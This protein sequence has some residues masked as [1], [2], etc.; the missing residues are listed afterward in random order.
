MLTEALQTGLQEIEPW[1]SSKRGVWGAGP[2]IL[3][4]VEL[5]GMKLYVEIF[6]EL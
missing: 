6:I 1:T 3:M 4:G 5:L 2:E